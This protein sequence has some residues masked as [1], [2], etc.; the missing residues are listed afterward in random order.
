MNSNELNELN[1][2]VAKRF[3]NIV[4]LLKL[5]FRKSKRPRPNIEH[6]GNRFQGQGQ[7]LA[8]LNEQP[9]ISQKELT[10]QLSMR[11]QSASEM[12]GKLERKGYL[13]RQKSESDKRV[14]IVSLT[15]LGKDVIENGESP[16]FEPLATK[17][18]TEEERIE[19]NRLLEKM[20]HAMAEEL[21]IKIEN[22]Q[23]NPRRGF[24]L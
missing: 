23:I 8:I 12:I 7:I 19:L 10:A 17:A 18:L 22:G 16:I 15:P 3:M 1:M 24:R 20:E 14:M 21:N 9:V 2:Q 11:P 4:A 13:T 6:F 5:S